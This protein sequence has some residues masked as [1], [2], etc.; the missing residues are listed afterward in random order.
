MSW[1]FRRKK[2]TVQDQEDLDHTS[3]IGADPEGKGSSTESGQSAVSGRLAPVERVSDLAEETISAEIIKSGTGDPAELRRRNTATL[4]KM[5]K[6]ELVDVIYTMAQKN[7]LLHAEND[8]MQ[9]ELS[10][11]TVRMDSAGSIAEASVQINQILMTAQNTADDYVKSVRASVEDPALREKIILETI[12]EEEKE[13]LRA[14]TLAAANK[15]A[16]EIRRKAG[17]EA[18]SIIK[19]ADEEA[20]RLKKSAD[21]EAENVR[22]QAG[23]EAAK[24]KNK[25]RDEAARC[26]QAAED[27]ARKLR[28]DSENLARQIALEAEESARQVRLNADSETEQVK[29]EA[30][31][32][33][34]EAKNEAEKTRVEAL[35]IA[36][37]DAAKIREEAQAEAEASR[38]GLHV[39][40]EQTRLGAL[41]NVRAEAEALRS[42]I[43]GDI[44]GMKAQ[45]EKELSE[46]RIKHENA[47]KEL[48]FFKA[49]QAQ[50]EEEENQREDQMA[51]MQQ[52]LA[53]AKKAANPY[54]GLTP[55]ECFNAKLKELAAMVR[56]HPELSGRLRR[57]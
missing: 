34:E 43:L 21:E 57:N 55:E 36:K 10:E 4:K 53:E 7:K 31:R 51:R 27:D 1:F 2:K 6:A 42:Q 22:R 37:S 52:L 19:S 39:I 29:S 45:A 50:I 46:A 3:L 5:S 41:E 17:K 48:S 14:E 35:S 8:R 44:E 25:A 30:F 47:K 28:V 49:K 11:R 54:E 40:E 26:R 24:L 33:L 16:D 32:A 18:E 20:K 56:E 13:K 38:A 23:D 15:E 9:K 12:S